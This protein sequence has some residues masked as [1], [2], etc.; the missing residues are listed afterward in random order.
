MQRLKIKIYGESRS[1]RHEKMER[2]T[3]RSRLVNS[4]DKDTLKNVKTWRN[5]GKKQWNHFDT[6]EINAK[7]PALISPGA[8]GVWR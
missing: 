8:G 6:D 2:E 4:V 7:S 3:E 1:G 5:T